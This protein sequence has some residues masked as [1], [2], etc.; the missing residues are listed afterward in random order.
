MIWGLDQDTAKPETTPS[1]SSNH[2]SE[3][4]AVLGVTGGASD[5]VTPQN[6]SLI[7][8]IENAT[9][10]GGQ[11]THLPNFIEPI[12]L[13]PMLA[14][15][16]QERACQY[17]PPQ[18]DVVHMAPVGVADPPLQQKVHH[19]RRSGRGQEV[20]VGLKPLPRR[21][22]TYNTT[23]LVTTQP[24]VGSSLPIII[25]ESQ[26]HSMSVP[27]KRRQSAMEIAQQYRKNQ[28]LFQPVAQSRRSSNPYSPPV[29]AIHLPT[30][31][32]EVS[33]PSLSNQTRAYNNSGNDVYLDS[34]QN[35]AYGLHHAASLSRAQNVF[36]SPGS[37]L[38]SYPRPPPNT[39]MNALAKSRAAN[40][41]LRVNHLPASPDSPSTGIRS[42]QYTKATP[43]S[44]LSNRRLSAVFEAFEDQNASV[45]MR[46]LSPPPFQQNFH[47]SRPLIPD[48][49]VHP[50]C[51]RNLAK[52]RQSNYYQL[53]NT[54]KVNATLVSEE[55]AKL[56]LESSTPGWI[57]SQANPH[58]PVVK[59]DSQQV[60]RDRKT[61]KPGLSGKIRVQGQKNQPQ[62]QASGRRNRSKKKVADGMVVI[63]G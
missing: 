43:I 22:E 3:T 41:T 45:G 32:A 8:N 51:Y 47:L 50:S 52:D 49:T 58:V 4:V 19:E 55:F 56:T 62:G 15:R 29:Q 9:P 18:I 21:H 23:P 26:P 40:V 38:G 13:G 11:N 48:G 5:V 24:V 6:P 39:P 36:V 30:L 14:P 54:S 44:R 35:S 59:V 2:T 53:E 1:E 28:A 25:L 42:L 20:G 63:T 27:T 37:D 31:S 61:G 34:H 57:Q 46:P 60:R 10:V 17:Q 33:E 7:I 16:I 12:D